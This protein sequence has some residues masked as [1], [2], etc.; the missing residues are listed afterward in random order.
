[1]FKTIIKMM[2]KPTAI[3][4]PMI[5]LNSMMHLSGLT[6]V[7]QTSTLHTDRFSTGIDLMVAD[8][9]DKIDTYEADSK[10]IIS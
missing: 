10:F 6:I 7:S 4:N 1:M 5:D 2:K 3:S 9:L 8:D